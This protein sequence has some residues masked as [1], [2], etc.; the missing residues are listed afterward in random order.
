MPEMK[1]INI[2]CWNVRTL[3]PG[4]N[5]LPSAETPTRKTAI[6]DCELARLN[7]DICALSETRLSDSGYIREEE[8]TVFWRGL[9]AQERRLYGVGFAI[10]NSLLPF[11][12][13]PVSTNERLMSLKINTCSGPVHLISAYAPTLQASDDVKD[14]FYD[15]LRNILVKIP[16]KQPVYVLGDFNARVGSDHASWPR[17]IGTHGIGKVNE[18]GQRVLELCAELDLCVTNT[19][20]SG[21]V[22]KKVTW[23]HPRSGHWHQLDLVLSR[24][25]LLHSVQHTA[26]MHSADCDTDHALVRCKIRLSK[27]TRSRNKAYQPRRVPKMETDNM[28]DPGLLARFNDRLSEALDPPSFNDIM[29]CEAKWCKLRDTLQRV[30]KE[31]RSEVSKSKMA[32]SGGDPSTQVPA[33][34]RVGSPDGRRPEGDPI[35]ERAIPLVIT[36]AGTPVSNVIA[37]QN[38][39]DEYL[40]DIHPSWSSPWRG[41]TSVQIVSSYLY[42]EIPTTP[43]RFSVLS[44][45]EE[46]V[47][48]IPT[49][50]SQYKQRKMTRTEASK[51]GQTRGVDYVVAPYEAQLAF[52]SM[53]GAQLH[54]TSIAPAMVFIEHHLLKDP[55][56]NRADLISSFSKAYA[57]SRSGMMDKAVLQEAGIDTSKFTG[58]STR[59]ASLSAAARRGVSTRSE[60]TPEGW[61]WYRD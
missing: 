15:L 5:T 59:R 9:A 41:G 35:R 24:R 58:H 45:K 7:I 53:N 28:S 3:C 30:G 42:P 31:R 22:M 27:P 16:R 39:K 54:P 38:L 20:F 52:F 47:F 8:Y 36:L 29:P 19:Y 17:Q 12:D 6:L 2:A 43:N 34:P 26:S 13:T 61:I 57:M 48:P 55:N 10:K 60:L 21:R 11:T 18:N 49:K 46:E 51:G 14:S 50:P 40:I 33:R 1:K 44:N 4:F 37:A 32:P 25:H 56:V 23:H